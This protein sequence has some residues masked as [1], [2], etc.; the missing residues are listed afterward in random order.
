MKVTDKLYQQVKPIWES[1]NQNPFVAGIED[2][3][4]EIEKFK[5]YLIQDY[6]YLLDYAKVFAYGV[7]KSK[8]ERHMK[9]FSD[10]IEMVVSSETDTHKGYMKELNIS[11]EDASNTPVSLTTASY[12]KYMLAVAATEG[13]AEIAVAVLACSWSYKHIADAMSG[14]PDHGFYGKWVD[15]YSSDSYTVFNDG[16]IDLVNELTS[17]YNEAQI[18]NLADILIKCSRYEY[19]FWDMGWNQSF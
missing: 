16:L 17:D 4:L 10:M 8:S 13:I 1:C 7:I 2:G 12:T 19:M 18:A 14:T 11:I 6:L 3:S 5:F 15:T 9:I